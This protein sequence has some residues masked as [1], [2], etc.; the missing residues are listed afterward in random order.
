MSDNNNA[1]PVDILN[2]L[3]KAQLEDILRNEYM[4]DEPDIGLIKRVNQVL[5]NKT[6][7][8]SEFDVNA[9]WREFE[10]DYVGNEP[11]YDITDEPAEN[12]TQ[13]P[14]APRKIRPSIG[15]AVAMIAVVVLLSGTLTAYALGYDVIEA[16]ASWTK[17]TF[18]FTQQ[19]DMAPSEV[20]PSEDVTQIS[21]LQ[22]ALCEYGITEKLVPTYI[23]NGYEQ[24]EF[25][26]DTSNRCTLFTSV[27]DNGNDTII[28]QIRQYSSA[29]D[30]ADYEKDIE[31][32]EVYTIDDIPHY[33]MTNM[34]E[35]RAI[36]VNGMHEV[37]IS[38]VKTKKE[39]EKMIGSIY[40]EK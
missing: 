16:I 20:T 9:K 11:L 34:G 15:A 12:Q 4:S 28:I 29:K 17:E 22:S 7:E 25:Y 37:N 27:L 19:T 38:G 23:P 21:D 8:N 13:I 35:Y 3:T 30:R 33:I 31:D 32:P 6:E 40:E 10:T 36:W 5:K 18:S 2:A 24:T 26:V 39:L 1:K 14:T